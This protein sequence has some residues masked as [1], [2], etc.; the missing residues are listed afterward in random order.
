MLTTVL[1]ACLVCTW[2]LK[3]FDL[4]TITTCVIAN[5]VHRVVCS[6]MFAIISFSFF[7]WKNKFSQLVRYDRNNGKWK[8]ITS[9]C[10]I[11]PR[12]NQLALY[13]STGGAPHWHR[14][15]QGLNP[16]QGPVSRKSRKLLGPEKPFV[17]LWPAYSVKLVFSYV[18]KGIKIKVTAKFRASRRL[19][20][21]DTKRIMSP[22]MRPKRPP[23]PEFFGPLSCY[24][25]KCLWS[26][27]FH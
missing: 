26:E 2:L 17:R 18:V 8:L 21:E 10:I 23:R 22:E 25:L 13:S 6:I 7:G 27:I 12:N 19:C 14:R 3:N 11:D 16:V 20:F 24:S 9:K 1:F 5:W 4:S 15:G